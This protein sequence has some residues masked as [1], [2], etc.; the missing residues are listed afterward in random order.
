[1]KKN[2]YEI[3]KVDSTFTPDET[4]DIV[5]LTIGFLSSGL[6]L[7]E[8]IYNEIKKNKKEKNDE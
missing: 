6:M 3:Q 1:M 8:L 7:A 5:N 4:K 2:N